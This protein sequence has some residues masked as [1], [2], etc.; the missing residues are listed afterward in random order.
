MYRVTSCCASRLV[1]S[2]ALHVSRLAGTCIDAA[3]LLLS[4][5]APLQA[6]LH[7]ASC[8][9]LNWLL[10]Q[11]RLS[12]VCDVGGP[13]VAAAGALAQRSSHNQACSCVYLLHVWPQAVCGVT[14]SAFCRLLA[15]TAAR[16]V[17]IRQLFDLCLFSCCGLMDCVVAAR[18]TEPFA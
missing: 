16:S 12:R 17:C 15:S 4:Q 2:E 11:L 18:H 13:L 9:P 7:A 10:L 8:R 14:G 5:S 6:M 1:K 3:R